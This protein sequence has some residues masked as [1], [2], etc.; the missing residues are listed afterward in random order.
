L[1]LN[2]EEEKEEA[3]QRK[4]LTVIAVVLVCSFFLPT[5]GHSWV[6]KASNDFSTIESPQR[7]EKL[8]HYPVEIVVRFHEG[9]KPE[10]FRAWLN[11][12]DITHRFYDFD[13]GKRAFLG[14][15]D[16]LRVRREDSRHRWPKTNI[17]KTRIAGIAQK[18]KWK[19]KKK[20][21]D[22]RAFFVKA[23][24]L[25]E[26][27][28]AVLASDNKVLRT[29]IR[30]AEP[31]MT[32]VLAGGETFT[33]L[34]FPG[35][36]NGTAAGGPQ[37][38]GA[39]QIQMYHRLMAVP[40]GAQPK[41]EVLSLTSRELEGINLYPHQASP[42]DIPGSDIDTIDGGPPPERFINPPFE[43]DEEAYAE[44]AFF[45]P[46][47]VSVQV[48]GQMRDVNVIQLSIA[49]AQ[50]NPV[51]Q[52]LK[53]NEALAAEVKFDGGTEYFLSSQSLN[54]FES[55]NTRDIIKNSLLNGDILHDHVDPSQAT[56]MPEQC[57]G[58]ELIII[59]D[60]DFIDAAND[61][62]DWKR[63]K[64]IVTN[65][66]ETDYDHGTDDMG[67][68]RELIRDF[69]Q[70]RYEDCVIRPSYVLL[71]GDAEFIP[72]WYRATTEDPT[73]GTDLDYSLL[74]GND[75]L[76]DVGL[77]RI[78]VDTKEQAQTVVDKIIKYEK[79]PPSPVDFYNHAAFP[80]Y[81]QCCR[82]DVFDF[83]TAP[84]TMI[85]GITSRAYIET[86]ELIRDALV[87]DGYTVDRLY[88]SDTL[89]HTSPPAL[90]ADVYTGNPTP[91][92]YFDQTPLPAGINPTSGF[93]WNATTTDIISAI[94]DGRFLVI[95]RNHGDES[96]WQQPPFGTGAV[97]TL[98]NK[99]LLPVLF[100]VDCSTGLF[101]NETDPIDPPDT[102]RYHGVTTAGEYLLEALLRKEKG[103]VVGAL[104]D[105][106]DSPSWANNALVRGF[107]DAIF[108]AVLPNHGG[109]TSIRRLA[110]ILNYGKL[111]MF[112]QVG[113]AQTAGSI[114][115]NA[116]D[117]DNIIW[118][119]F[120]DPTL[121]IWTSKPFILAKAYTSE[122]L[123]D[124]LLVS[125][126]EEGA[127]ITATQKK[128]EDTVPIGR[129]TVVNGQ[130]EIEFLLNPDPQEP[131]ELFA[132][133]QGAV[134]TRLATC[135]PDLPDPVLEVIGS[136]DYEVDGQEFT[137]YLLEVTN[138]GDYPDELFVPAPHL[139][140][141]GLNTDSS[142]TW[143]DIYD[144]NDNRLYGFCDLSSS[145]DLHSL[146]F[147]TP[148][149]ATPPASVYIEIV[150]RE[151]ELTY[152]SNLEPIIEID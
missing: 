151:C 12:R 39:P 53:L 130:A 64:G 94:D 86:V 42:V 59:T 88:S 95:H 114:V 91:R 78:P 112:N 116:A 106:R 38:V 58:E 105:T 33:R 80:A 65:V 132:S 103:G 127:V 148:R 123:L 139:P 37:A 126:A 144:G 150:D 31:M 66:Y 51:T 118:H 34:S 143:V 87:A 73:T 40:I 26:T 36:E 10:T 76:A 21:T 121:E 128:D 17:L 79:S 13:N 29:R 124:R 119:A 129:A 9:A 71:I 60:V 117:R 89:H 77:A 110:D 23:G 134:S 56:P 146:W 85:E 107:A 69:I 22:V 133:K 5:Q 54:P 48:V 111:Y 120:G 84:P 83:T 74:T 98:N 52:T 27:E 6:N 97:V 4:A 137:R 122:G 46:E 30:F 2:K 149:G 63:A 11:H 140:P 135:Y 142:R 70:E 43:K 100:S 68:T 75:L 109:T 28:T 81:F 72:P 99:D 57:L 141:C 113:V 136:E 82:N 50:Y 152:T 16:G 104:G 62:R 92:M 32:T 102:D 44:D 8:N 25:A 7:L 93:P 24:P 20:D 55:Y 108:P 61:L 147:A 131:I 41:L 138:S 47:A 125:Y 14:P 18:T 96:G 1:T 45:P 115:Q 35:L 145:D 3:M 19:R 101:D 67:E 49:P 15:E 90:P